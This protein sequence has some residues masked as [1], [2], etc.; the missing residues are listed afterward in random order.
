MALL[1]YDPGC[2]LLKR[3]LFEAKDVPIAPF[4][5][6]VKLEMYYVGGSFDHSRGDIGC[7]AR[8]LKF[9]DIFE[10]QV[11][12]KQDVLIDAL[13]GSASKIYLF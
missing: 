6:S 13:Y 8:A 12:Q 2:V 1:K 7:G 3:S 11:V 4:C 5:W 10:L 9:S